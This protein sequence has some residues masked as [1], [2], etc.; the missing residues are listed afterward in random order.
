M[1]QE[2]AIELRPHIN[3]VPGTYIIEGT[4]GDEIIYDQKGRTLVLPREEKKQP[5]FEEK[6]VETK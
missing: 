2:E 4:G 5:V 3:G 6:S 1:A